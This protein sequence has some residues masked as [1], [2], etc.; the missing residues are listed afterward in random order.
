MSS[1]RSRNAGTRSSIPPGQRRDGMALYRELAHRLYNLDKPVISAVDGVAYGA[2]VSIMLLSDFV[3]VS[4]RARMALVF[5]RIGLIP[6]VG[7]WFTLPR[8]A[9]IQKARELIFSAREFLA[10]EA[11]DIG[12]ANEVLAPD[13]LMPRALVVA[14]SLATA[15]PTAMSMSK[16]ALRASLQSE[17]GAMMDL[18][19]MAQPIA[20]SSEFAAEAI[21]RFAAKEPPQFQWPR[22]K[23]QAS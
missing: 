6:D 8:I 15:S 4:S 19:A 14:Q 20:G 7:A 12:I 17:F 9:G 5:H 11:R 22:Q 1:T 2:G 10:D 21:R 23:D 18:E 16:Q 3:F 13:D